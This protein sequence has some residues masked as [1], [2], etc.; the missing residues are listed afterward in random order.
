MSSPRVLEVPVPNLVPTLKLKQAK[1]QDYMEENAELE[2]SFRR[3]QSESASALALGTMDFASTGR[4]VKSRGK[5]VKNK[6]NKGQKLSN[7][8]TD[9][10][11]TK[12]SN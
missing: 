8:K 11:Q 3:P 12:G 5:I 10:K 2:F 9:I 1:R 4:S 7:K 6:Q